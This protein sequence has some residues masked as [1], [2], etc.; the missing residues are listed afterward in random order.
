MSD[1]PK[2]YA[3]ATV[4]V[5]VRAA[6]VADVGAMVDIHNRAR[7]TYYRGVLPDELLDDPA[8]HARRH[9]AWT[10]SVGTAERTVLCAERGGE[11]VGFALLGPPFEPVTGV[12]PATVGQLVQLNVRPEHW[13]QRIGLRLHD[14][15]VD[16]WRAGSIATARLE[17]WE[18]NRRARTFYH[19]L[20]WRPDGHRR[21]DDGGSAFLRLC[22]AVPAG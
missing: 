8:E 2:T 16:A 7:D 19:R 18:H 13:G 5:R 14:A 10:R 17:V 1:S 20:G 9:E 6:T 4:A 3:T 11:V 15:C 22:L 12:D 21:D